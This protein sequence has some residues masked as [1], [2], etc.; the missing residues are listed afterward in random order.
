M[1][2][3]GTALADSFHTV[4]QGQTLARI[5]RRYGLSQRALAQANRLRR[6]EVLRVGMQ[7][8]IPDGSEPTEDIG[9]RHHGSIQFLR[10]NNGEEA[11]MQLVRRDGRI[12]PTAKRRFRQLLRSLPTGAI[13]DIHPRLLQ[14]VQKVGDRWPH[15]KLIVISGFREHS[16]GRRHSRHN[17]GRAMDFRVE[18]VANTVVRDYCKTLGRVGVGY[19]PNSTF[20]HLDV[21]ERSAYWIDWS[22]PGEHPRYRRAETDVDPADPAA[23]QPIEAAPAAG[24]AETEHEEPEGDPSTD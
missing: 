17:E 18:G 2:F 22:H 23:A 12:N 13:H 10:L 20:V 8:R 6:D 4:R 19:Y 1:A 5:A 21:R 7:L 14:L 3:A 15:K 11:R 24:A 16:G 9:R